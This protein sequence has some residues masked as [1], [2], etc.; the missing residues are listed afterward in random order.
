MQD[1]ADGLGPRLANN[2]WATHRNLFPILKDELVPRANRA[3]RRWWNTWKT[4]DW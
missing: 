2:P 3:W 1:W 4:G